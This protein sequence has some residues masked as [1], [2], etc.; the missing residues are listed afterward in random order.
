[1]ATQATAREAGSPGEIF[2]APRRGVLGPHRSV[3]EYAAWAGLDLATRRIHPDARSRR[4][5]AATR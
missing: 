5:P 1:M 3:E 4:R 2:V